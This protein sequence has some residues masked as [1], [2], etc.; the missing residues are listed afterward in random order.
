MLISSWCF[1][2]KT[3]HFNAT[4]FL[5]AG[6]WI[7][8]TSTEITETYEHL[9]IEFEGGFYVYLKLSKKFGTCKKLLVF[10]DQWAGEDERLLRMVT[11]TIHNKA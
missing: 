1:A 6:S 7:L 11:T 8:Q 4:L 9:S 3:I 10:K 5:R 2:Y